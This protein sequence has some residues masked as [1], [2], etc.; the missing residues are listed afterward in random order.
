ME[1]LA[2]YLFKI[3]G[4]ESTPFQVIK[5]GMHLAPYSPRGTKQA[6]LAGGH[7]LGDV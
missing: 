3:C 2:V 6:S 4:P 5:D 1:I 7:W